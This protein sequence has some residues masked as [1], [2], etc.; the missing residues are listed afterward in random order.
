MA[1][2]YQHFSSKMNTSGNSRTRQKSEF[3]RKTG[4]REDLL[5]SWKLTIDPFQTPVAEQEVDRVGPQ[6]YE[7]YTPPILKACSLVEDEN[8]GIQQDSQD[9]L[10]ALKSD[11][12]AFVFA[13]PGSGKT[14]LR[15]TLEADCRMIPDGTLAI[16][17]KLGRNEQA[18]VSP[19]SHSVDHGYRLAQALASDLV[20]TIIEQFDFL[21]L[22][23]PTERQIQDIRKLIYIG[24]RR[25]RR[26]L[27][28]MQERMQQEDSWRDTAWGLSSD[29]VAIGKMP[30]QY[31]GGNPRLQEFLAAILQD[32]PEDEHAREPSWEAFWEGIQIARTWGFQ[33][34]FVLVDEVDDRVKS[35][36]EM[37]ALIMPLLKKAENL[38]KERIFY[39]MFLPLEMQNWMK[40]AFCSQQTLLCSQSYCSIIEWSEDALRAL[41]AQRFQAAGAK[42][43]I[44]LNAFVEDA[45]W[46]LEGAMIKAAKQGE[47]GTPRKLLALVNAI[48]DAH[49]ENEPVNRFLSRE[50]WS[51]AQRR[52]TFER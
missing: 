28:N 23:S 9:S 38:G 49:V 48:I 30:V 8:I 24:G 52:F 19:K 12:H 51:K 36:E 15:L 34:F 47:G 37:G 18:S 35:V 25:L 45:S 46:D 44:S 20:L 4:S 41:L 13:P 10:Q 27:R 7:Y 26:V 6:F 42:R 50:D 3:D 2:S 22:S 21:S 39:K 14:T 40:T 43:Y 31:V 17:Y 16:T 32:L 5:K 11:Q 29:W 33:R 1:M